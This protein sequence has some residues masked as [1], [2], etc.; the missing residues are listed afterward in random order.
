LTVSGSAVSSTGSGDVGSAATSSSASVKADFGLSNVQLG[1]AAVTA[2]ATG[3]VKIST[4]STTGSVTDSNL[5][6]TGN[7]VKSL[8]QVN[9]AVNDLSIT[10][11]QQNGITAGLVSSQDSSAA[12]TAT[13]SPTASAF[14]ISAAGLDNAKVV[15]SGNTASAVA[16]KNEAFNTLTVSGANILGRGNNVTGSV[17]GTSSVT[18]AD[19]AVINAQ[20]ASGAASA[21]VDA[22]A[23]GFVSSAGLTG[24][25]VTLSGNV[26]L[27]SAN[28]NTSGNLLNLAATN[29]LEA[30]GVVNNVQSL[31]A[32][33]TVTATVSSSSALSV[34]TDS[35]AGS[36]GNATVAVTGNVVKA[37][38]SAN[39]AANVL[40]ASGSNGIAGTGAVTSPSGTTNTPTFAVLNS[41]HTGSGSAVTS[42]INGFNMGGAQLNGALNSGG[43][44]S[45]TGNVVQ[46][47]AYGNSASNAIQVAALPAGLNT[48]SASITN[49]QYNL[50]SV[51]S[52]ISG[53]NVQGSGVNSSGNGGVNI[54]GNSVVAMAAGNRVVNTITGR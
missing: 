24:G 45:V 18:G 2:Q 54:S 19:F 51:T 9:S 43:S 26:V 20:S 31:A 22:G 37:A 47:V 27:A 36:A 7:A 52:T 30:S 15:V 14:G 39:V 28:A 3:A 48:A 12:V 11:T 32:A 40:N 46:S 41:Q 25:S 34:E 38:A 16:G 6:L 5:S 53:V 4:D 29:S 21:T 50:S 8:A 44:A 10:S 13:T 17:A 33:S 42:V 35:A 49:V 23:S 1:S